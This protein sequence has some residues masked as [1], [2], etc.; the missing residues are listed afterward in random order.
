LQRH[1]SHT[2]LWSVSVTAMLRQIA[3]LGWDAEL[4]TNARR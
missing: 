3:E 2:D 1:P 4:G